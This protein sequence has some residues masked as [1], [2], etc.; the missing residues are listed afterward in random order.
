MLQPGHIS[1][2]SK[3]FG[4]IG[5]FIEYQDFFRNGTHKI[6][7]P[8]IF[9]PEFPV[10]IGVLGGEGCNS[11]LHHPSSP[12][13]I[14]LIRGIREFLFTFSLLRFLY[15]QLNLICVWIL[16]IWTRKRRY[17]KS[18]SYDFRDWRIM[19]I[20]LSCRTTWVPINVRLHHYCRT[21]WDYIV[22]QH[23]IIIKHYYYSLMR[24]VVKRES[25]LCWNPF[26]ESYID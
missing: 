12:F 23:E 18:D 25:F 17:W 22:V 26:L 9:P 13:I 2:V 24:K 10:F 3:H 1:A 8:F 7:S 14:L 19:F 16:K 15:F 5:V 11:T 6:S 21:T 20:R 4:N